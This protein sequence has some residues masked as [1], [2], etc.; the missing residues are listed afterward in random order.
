MQYKRG[1]VRQSILVWFLG[2]VCKKTRINWNLKMAKVPYPV[3]NLKYFSKTCGTEIERNIPIV[4]CYIVNISLTKQ[5]YH[6]VGES[7]K[8]NRTFWGSFAILITTAAVTVAHDFCRLGFRLF[9][10]RRFRICTFDVVD[11]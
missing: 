6:S 10:F 9:F 11:V 7:V 1:R 4:K 2:K 3:C 8:T 5:M